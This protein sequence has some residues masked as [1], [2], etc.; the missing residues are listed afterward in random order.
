MRHLIAI[1]TIALCA[2]LPACTATGAPTYLNE[3]AVGGGYD[4]PVGHNGGL[5][6]DGSGNVQT[7]GSI[8]TDGA[9]NAEDLTLSGDLTVAGTSTLGVL[10]AAGPTTLAQPVSVVDNL[11][12]ANTLVQIV[13]NPEVPGSGLGAFMNGGIYAPD[14]VGSTGIAAIGI[15]GDLDDQSTN[16]L[17]K[18]WLGETEGTIFQ[19]VMNIATG[20]MSMLLNKDDGDATIAISNPDSTYKTNL[21]VDGDTATGGALTAATATIGGVA[22]TSKVTGPGASTDNAVARY[23]GTGNTVQNSGVIIDDSNNVTGVVGLTASTATIGGV[24]FTTKVSGPGS[25][26][27]NAVMRFDGT[28]GKTAQN[29]GVLIGDS[30]DV[31]GANSIAIG[32]G[33]GSTGATIS[34]AGAI[35]TNSN[36][37]VDGTGLFT[38]QLTASTGA[39]ILNMAIGGSYMGG[40]PYSQVGVQFDLTAPANDWTLGLNNPNGTYEANLAVE[41]DTTTGGLLSV[42]GGYGSTGSLFSAAGDIQANGNLTVDGTSYLNGA[43]TAIGAYTSIANI[44]TLGNIAGANLADNG[45]RIHNPQ[46]A[47][48]SSDAFTATKS[49]IKL[50]SQTGTSDNLVTINGGTAGEE[51][52]IRPVSGHTITVVH[53]SGNIKCIGGANM[54][55]SPYEHAVLLY[56][57]DNFWYVLSNGA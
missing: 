4:D 5:T 2:V 8:S 28:G 10:N 47:T 40:P 9:L 51:I 56:E 38:G 13:E 30:N 33:Y 3:L 44:T 26:T 36:L 57:D 34:S 16:R 1:L 27:D 11:D 17:P 55:L 43:I 12:D 32:G 50:T 31:T 19:M 14:T 37:I 25:S 45:K 52:I 48:L 22:Y 23:N 6:V 21:T 24:A 7:N 53:N 18:I 46:S 54:V 35:S 15:L 49:F 20:V 41:G 39:T 42:G 29:S